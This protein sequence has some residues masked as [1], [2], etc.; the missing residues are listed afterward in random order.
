MDSRFRLSIV[1]VLTTKD[2]RNERIG[3]SISGLAKRRQAPV[4]TNLPRNT[5]LRLIETVRNVGRG[6]QLLR[7]T[8]N[9]TGR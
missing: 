8:V 1:F 4:E 7:P 6:N 9:I 3:Y 2:Y 5:R